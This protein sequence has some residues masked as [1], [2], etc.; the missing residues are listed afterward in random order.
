MGGRTFFAACLLNVSKSGA[1]GHV[2]PLWA[3]L[4]S[5]AFSGGIPIPLTISLTSGSTHGSGS[6]SLE[7]NF[8][9]CLVPFTHLT[10]R[11]W[12]ESHQTTWSIDISVNSISKKRNKDK[13]HVKLMLD[14]RIVY[15]VKLK[16]L[17]SPSRVWHGDIQ[18]GRPILSAFTLGGVGA[19]VFFECP[20][21]LSSA[22]S[23]GRTF[24]P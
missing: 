16:L 18:T 20:R 1:S 11:I 21:F 15:W 22:I 3:L 2:P 6:P 14:A 9:S 4:Y 13:L 8:Q 19:D 10:I 24:R 7:C 23:I 17:I 12:D 5:I